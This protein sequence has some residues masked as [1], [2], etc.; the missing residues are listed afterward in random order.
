MTA[1]TSIHQLKGCRRVRSSGL[2]SLDLFAAALAAIAATAVLWALASPAAA[3]SVHLYE[4]T[5]NFPSGSDPSAQGVDLQ[6]N[7]YV[8]N[9]GS[10]TVEKFDPNGNPVNFSAL[11]TNKLDGAGG[12][13]CPT[14]P[15]D[16][17]RVPQGK[18]F[19]TGGREPTLAV[20]ISDGPTS[21]YIYV[22]NAGSGPGGGNITSKPN[23]VLEVFDPS[24]RFIGELNT[25]ADGP[26][27]FDSI[28]FTVNVDQEGNI[29]LHGE[30]AFF[31]AIDKFVP[32]DGVP[33]HDV[34]GGQ[35]R[36]MVPEYESINGYSLSSQDVAG[37]IPYTYAIVGGFPRSIHTVPST[38]TTRAPITPSTVMPARA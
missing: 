28:P 34:F 26:K 33:A 5:W 36:S 23:A 27:H 4:A 21:G 6:G 13:N 38:P 1:K 17:D 29:Y 16:C 18:F 2:K 12:L 22:D 19:V 15:S 8:Y 7:V 20:D 30:R 25:N 11:G 37:G 35:I 9:I 3:N 14:T 31:A 32:V 24:G 10:R